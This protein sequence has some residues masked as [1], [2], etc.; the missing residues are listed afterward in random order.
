[1]IVDHTKLQEAVQHA[2]T[3][4]V[5]MRRDHQKLVTTRQD[6]DRLIRQG[7]ETLTEYGKY[8]DSLVR[9]LRAIAQWGEDE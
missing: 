8:K 5:G 4:L 7:Q 9:D 6:V 2:Q 3:H 1:M